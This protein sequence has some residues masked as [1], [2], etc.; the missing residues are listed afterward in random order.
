MMYFIAIL[1]FI[2]STIVHAEIDT[3]NHV[4]RKILLFYHGEVNNVD[5][6]VGSYIA[7]SISMPLNYMGYVTETR[8]IQ[9]PLPNDISPTEYAGVI[10]AI[11]GFL[12]GKEQVLY[13]WY[14][15]VLK[16]HI[17]LIILNNFGFPLDNFDLTPFQ[18]SRPSFAYD[19][20]MIKP[21]FTSPIMGYEIAPRTQRD[22]FFP[23]TIIKGQLLYQ[24][25]DE[26]GTKADT[27]A[28]MP[29]GGYYI[30]NSF[31]VPL[32]ENNY[33]WAI[34]PF[35]FFKTALRLP[36]MPI[37]DTTT[38]NGNRL[39]FVHIDGDGFANHSNQLNG[40][41]VGEVLQHEILERYKIPTTVSII[42]GE[43]AAN[44]LH[45][46]FS[47]QLEAIAK[48]IFKLPYV[49]IASHTYSHPFNWNSALNYHGVKPNPYILPIPNYKFD[50]YTEVV[51]SVNY[52][53]QH[54]AP[55]NKFCKMFLW[56]GE[57]DIPQ[58]ALKLTYELNVGNI[59][60]G[61]IITKYNN[62]LTGV[63]AL[64]I[65]EG[66]YFQV[67]A[68]IGNDDETISHT[69]IFYSLI[70]IIDALKL[71]DQPQRLKPIDIYY[72]FYSMAQQGGVKALRLIYEW[73]L[74]QDVMN[75]YASD[76]YKKVID[77]NQLVIQNQHDGW[78]IKTKDELRELRILQTMGYPDLEKSMNVIGYSTYN[79][80][81][82]IHLN[83]GGEAF[84]RLT[85]NAPTLPYLQNANTRIAS[86]KRNKQRV[87]FKFQPIEK[88]KFTLANMQHC[89]LW[90]GT[91]MILAKLQTYSTKSYE[92]TQGPTDELF[93][94]CN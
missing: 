69:N 40:M 71:T 36:D 91:Q 1:M 59:N 88:L 89:E 82:Y 24:L 15:S 50:L 16:K 44:G 25:I 23:L 13:D 60:P 30:S 66:P 5:E 78:L 51:G 8:N 84:I 34:N 56:S 26:L 52:I 45:P 35:I 7:K 80:S 18:L 2:T 22:A 73:A 33:R 53:N 28:I 6:K 57:G 87:E 41:F 62:S 20:H 32:I 42:Q 64:G 14:L 46:D 55:P 19:S 85:P 31:L 43:I 38:E 75:I 9:D 3:T 39:M 67:F 47:S 27:A 29:W 94:Q 61:T 4:A 74:S 76:Y 72:H 54:L 58:E 21:N 83:A 77:F 68:P 81:R 93:V 48:S 92:F 12:F 65:D 63:S 37:P 79:D 10:V 17:P 11:D 70:G 49:E 90:H 86:F